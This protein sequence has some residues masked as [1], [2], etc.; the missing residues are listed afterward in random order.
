MPIY[1]KNNREIKKPKE[2]KFWSKD[3]RKTPVIILIMI[4]L[5]YAI[6]GWFATYNK[7]VKGFT[8]ETQVVVIQKSSK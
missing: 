3:F 1:D 6:M 8:T 7:M 5:G 2:L 4:I